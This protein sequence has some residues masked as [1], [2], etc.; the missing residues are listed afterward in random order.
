[1]AGL[2]ILKSSKEEGKSAGRAISAYGNG[3]RPINRVP[4][5]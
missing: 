3:R 4:L 2:K 1:V 5:L